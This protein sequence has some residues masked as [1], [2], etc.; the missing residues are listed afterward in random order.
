L[1]FGR[2]LLGSAFDGG[3]YYLPDGLVDGLDDGIGLRIVR[4]NAH[5]LDAG[6][7]NTKGEFAL[8]FRSTVMD[9][10]L[11]ARIAREIRA[12]KDAPSFFGGSVADSCDFEEIRD[13]FDGGERPKGKL[14]TVDSNV[15]RANLVDVNFLPRYPLCLAWREVSVLE[16]SGLHARTD[17]TCTELSADE[18]AQKRV[19]EVAAD[20]CFEAIHAFGVDGELMIPLD[21]VWND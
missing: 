9:N 12:T 8:K 10:A 18:L 6:V 19:V 21:D 20:G 4:R 1:F 15:P 2:K 13:R 14:E 11:W 7:G 16:P 17:F 3:A 5:R